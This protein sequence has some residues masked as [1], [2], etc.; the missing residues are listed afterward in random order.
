MTLT[1]L[2]LAGIGGGVTTPADLLAFPGDVRPPR[3]GAVAVYFL[4]PVLAANLAVFARA[5]GCRCSPSRGS[6]WTYSRGSSSGDPPDPAHHRHRRHRDRAE[7]NELF[8][9]RPVTDRMIAVSQG[10]HEHRLRSLRRDPA[11]VTC[12]WDGR[13]RPI[14]GAQRRSLV[15]LGGIVITLRCSSA[16]R[17][18]SSSRLPEGR[19]GRDPVLRGPELAITT[20]TLAARRRTSMSWLVVA[21]FAMWNMGAAFL[22]GVVFYQ[23]LQRGWVRL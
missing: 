11:S 21:G 12:R 22:A 5:S 13:P 7:N 6:G 1:T 9:D 14:R 8:P 15:M 4:D 2:G 18:A 17:W 20:R 3:P 19:A 23:V 16:T 10:R